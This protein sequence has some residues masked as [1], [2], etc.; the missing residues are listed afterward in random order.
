M[1]AKSMEIARGEGA[2]ILQIY[3][4]ITLH[5]LTAGES[6]PGKHTYKIRWEYKGQNVYTRQNMYY[7]LHK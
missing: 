1:S 3:E 6:Q 4:D 7:H 5:H 2:K